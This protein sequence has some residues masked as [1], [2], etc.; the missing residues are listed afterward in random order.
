MWMFVGAETILFLCFFA[1]YLVSSVSTLD[2]PVPK[3]LLELKSIL[4]PTFLLLSSSW[5]FYRAEKHFKNDGVR[6]TMV[7]LG[8]T[9]LCALLF[10]G[11][12]A[13]E[14][15]SYIGKGY[16]ITTS[17]FL[18]AFYVLV[19]THG[20]HVLFGSVWMM[21]ILWHC[22]R[23]KTKWTNWKKLQAFAIYWHFVD[24]VWVF[25][26][27]IVYVLGSQGAY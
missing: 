14:F 22:F 4:L 25:I 17:P 1:T 6:G 26:F 27:I 2:G 3:E 8:I 9:L 12:E 20:A 11:F 13:H 5:T 19:G 16:T 23:K 21:L 15:T 18:A 7:W 24:T 10:L